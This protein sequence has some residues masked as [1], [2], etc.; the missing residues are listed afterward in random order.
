[1]CEQLKRSDDLSLELLNLING[2]AAWLQKN[3]PQS[4]D[5][6]SE[7]KRV[8]DMASDKPWRN[9]VHLLTLTP[10]G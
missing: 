9:K 2:K 8:R 6:S 1:V 10:T 5:D 3:G 4:S 7:V